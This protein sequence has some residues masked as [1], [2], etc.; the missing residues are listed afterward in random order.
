MLRNKLVWRS[1][2]AISTGKG[3]KRRCGVSCLVDQQS[4]DQIDAGGRT[5]KGMQV[6]FSLC[7]LQAHAMVAKLW[8]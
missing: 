3:E 8:G 1:V 7:M 5:R 2:R 6:V 4:L